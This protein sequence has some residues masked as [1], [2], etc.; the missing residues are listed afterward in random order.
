[1]NDP[2]TLFIQSIKK[3]R[4][5]SPEQKREFLENPLLFPIEYRQKIID[6]LK[7]FDEKQ[8]ERYQ[9]VGKNVHA[10]N[11]KLQEKHSTDSLPKSQQEEVLTKV[12]EQTRFLSHPTNA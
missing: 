8:R 10:L 7:R 12:Y 3:S 6:I 5:F 11:A 2:L 4:L 1:M 9:K